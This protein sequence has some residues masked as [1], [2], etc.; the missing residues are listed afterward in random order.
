MRSGRRLLHWNT[1]M[2]ARV[3]RHH[4]HP[5]TSDNYGAIL[6]ASRESIGTDDIRTNDTNGQAFYCKRLGRWIPCGAHWPA[7]GPNGY[8]RIKR[9][10]LPGTRRLLPWELRKKTWDWDQ[11]RLWRRPNGERP[12]TISELYAFGAEHGVVQIV[13]EKHHVYGQ[14]AIAQEL[15]DEAREHDHPAWFMV[16]DDMGPRDKVAAM[17]QTDGGQIAMIFGTD[18]PEKPAGWADWEFYPNRMWGPDY[19]QRWLPA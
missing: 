5:T 18:G 17:R 1:R 16:L 13:E 8:T 19:T 11:V 14:L 7:P 9:K 3:H 10:H 15:V 2:P 6:R 12:R 4:E